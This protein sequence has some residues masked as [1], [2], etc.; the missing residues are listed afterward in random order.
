M[1]DLIEALTILRQYGNPHS[2]LNCA[3][4]ELTVCISPQLVP[5]GDREYLDKLGFFV[6]WGYDCF[7]SF[8]FG[9]A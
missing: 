9:S 8:R 1:D 7:K 2:P 6:D 4:D 5:A 3:H